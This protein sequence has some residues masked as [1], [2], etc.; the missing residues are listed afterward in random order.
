LPRRRPQAEPAKA[1]IVSLLDSKR[2]MNTAIAIARV[3]MSYPEIR[4]VILTLREG[5]LTG[6]Q[7]SQLLEFMPTTEEAETLRG[8]K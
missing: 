6:E 7:L 5:C 2:A 3:K 1:A 8:Y 4:D